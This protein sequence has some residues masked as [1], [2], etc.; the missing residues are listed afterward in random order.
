[1]A[2]VFSVF[3]LS[4]LAAAVPA[5]PATA[6]PPEP[7]LSGVPVER[8]LA[9]PA[10]H[11]Y[12]VHAAEGEAIHVRAAQRGI[13]VALRLLAPGGEESARA[14]AWRRPGTEEELLA[15]AAAAGPHTVEVRAA[16]EGLTPGPYRLLL[17]APRP[18]TEAD[19]RRA[20]AL[21][22]GEHALALARG[23]E[24][25]PADAATAAWREAIALWRAAGDRAHEADALWRRGMAERRAGHVHEAL[26][27]YGEAIALW[28]ALGDPG[29]EA[30]AVNSR[31]L[32]LRGL[33]RLEEAKAELERAAVLF[34]TLGDRRSEAAVFSNLALVHRVT[35]GREEARGLLLRSL[36]LARA[37][38]DRRAEVK[39]LINL[40]L[41]HDDLG[42][43]G[44]SLRRYREALALAR[45]LAD[46]Q[47]EAAALHN[48][49]GAYE[50][51]GRWEEA[52]PRSREALELMRAAGDRRGEAAGLNNVGLLHWR[53]GET[54]EA[55]ARFTAARSLAAQ[56]GEGRTEAR[57][58]GNLALLLREAGD[59]AAARAAL[60][61]ASALARAAGDPEIEGVVEHGL[62][63]LALLARQT[64]AALRHAAR[65]RELAR[66]VG[67]RALEADALLLTARAETERG[68]LA[69]AL[70]A[71][72]AA[73]AGVEALRAAVGGPAQ[74]A[75]FRASRAA[76]YE[77][78]V[79]VLMA[80]ERAEPG[81]G[82][83]AAALAAAE[84][85]KARSLLESLGEARAGLRQGADPALLAAERRA[86]QEVNAG[87]LAR[88]E[89]LRAR[90]APEELAAAERAFAAALG[91]LERIEGELRATSP[92][93]AGLTQPQALDLAALRAEVLDGDSVLLQMALGEERSFLWAV[94]R[95][96]LAS[97]ELPPRAEL[98][99]AVRAA[100]G[101][102]TE[103]NRAP[104]GETAAAR[105]ARLA[106]ADA[107]WEQ[108]ARELSQ[109]LL[110]P[111]RDLLGERR[112]LVVADGALDYLPFAALPDPATGEPLIAR[113]EVVTLPSASIVPLLRREPS[114]GAARRQ[115]L[116]VLADPVFSADDTRVAAAA[117]AAGNLPAALRGGVDEDR[118]APPTRLPRLRFSRREAEAIAALVPPAERLVALDFGAAR[119]LVE[120][121]GLAG[122]RLVHFATHGLLDS[123]HPELSSLV[124][125]LVDERG[126]PRDGYLRLHDI[127]NLRLDADLVVLSACRTALGREV[128]GEG[129]VGLT[130]GFMY[131]GSPRVVASLWSVEDRATA[132]L[133]QRFYRG[134]LADG[135]RPAAA[136]AAAQRELLADPRWRAPYHWAAFALHGEWR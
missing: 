122:Y 127:Y 78:W 40:G 33:G 21:A 54:A 85:A 96:G 91:E 70:A 48:L 109:R 7:L 64:D 60:E 68:A 130:R 121:G 27:T 12:T 53:L 38:G 63:R 26:A 18:A 118:E 66:G 47:G 56:L 110:A 36:E 65:S 32:A 71:A 73:V 10:V 13:D 129:L 135:L 114:A 92:R 112:L 116:A 94:T 9:P 76:V 87:E 17:E 6:A 69:P 50:A 128:R 75:A 49:A 4:W 72:E 35:G 24:G 103:R 22:A 52:L 16:A 89:R 93:Y 45:A 105:R 51:L 113:R 39:T 5:S 124:L 99:A 31:G 84:R 80:R 3:L 14:D 111:V 79:A 83:A 131:A 43:A 67:A 77:T 59:L 117:G 82:H 57:A 28:R 97:V 61:Q 11:V 1:M 98:E 95:D 37:A 62:G 30:D 86:R 119:P 2:G 29:G 23:G 106:A 58:L 134:I 136:L 55:R 8:Q 132:E 20:A 107:A 108:A 120:A 25:D 15:V 133:M 115:T 100:Y 101:H 104:A 41:V 123:R 125:S 19:R 102:L 42:E 88:V 34:A 44:E 126:A 81:R 74:R 46:R 90:A